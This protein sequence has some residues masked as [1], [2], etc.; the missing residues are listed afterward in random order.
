MNPII[1][2]GAYGTVISTINS[3]ICRKLFV[4][5][6]AYSF[7]REAYIIQALKH[8]PGISEI[9]EIGYATSED[10]RIWNAHYSISMLKYDITLREWLKRG[11]LYQER[12]KIL[13]ELVAIIYAIHSSNIIHGDLKLENIM[14][15]SNKKVRII[16][17]GLSGPDGYAKTNLTTSIYRAPK[18]Y[19]SFSDD[20]YA[21]GVISLELIFGSV[22]VD[23]PHYESCLRMINSAQLSSEFKQLLTNM[24][25]PKRKKRPNIETVREFF[26]ISKRSYESINL[27]EL[28]TGYI[29][30]AIF[31]YQNPIQ[32]PVF[33]HT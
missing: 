2:H 13:R 1:G 8:I 16:D 5:D 26:H 18:T 6:K 32:E 22:F 27:Q 20:I 4:K 15:N 30:E 21:L 33:D 3:N 25:A 24:I 10:K 23:T 28:Y 11:P 12:M 31:H 29:A 17:W 19:N 9:V 14:L 7:L